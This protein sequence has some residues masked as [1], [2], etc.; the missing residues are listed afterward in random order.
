MKTWLQVWTNQHDIE[1]LLNND[2]RKK[3]KNTDREVSE[4]RREQNPWRMERS[5]SIHVAS[6]TK[7][8][9]T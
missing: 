4:K 9:F 5:Q 3:N 6:R 2:L 1:I 8:K 7:D